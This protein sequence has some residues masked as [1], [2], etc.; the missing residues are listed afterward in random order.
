LDFGSVDEAMRAARSL[1]DLSGLF[2]INIHLFSASGPDAVRQVAALG[3]RIFLDLKY[4]DIP[5]TVAGA[6]SAA[7]ALPHVALIDV[8]TAGGRAMMRAA[9]DALAAAPGGKGDRK[10]LGITVL[11]SLDAAALEAVGVAGTP[12]SRAVS[13]ALLAKESG[14]D[15]VV[16]SPHEVSAIREACGRDFL[17]VVPGIRPSLPG[18]TRAKDDQARV[19]TPAEAIRAGADYLVIGRPILAAPDPRA[20]AQAIIDEIASAMTRG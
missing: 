5:N 12:K 4:H 19:A 11:T 18:G 20:A 9:A 10:L 7:A 6:V 16:A 3:P 2:K 8:H 13:R 15:G 14:L 1:A 17:I